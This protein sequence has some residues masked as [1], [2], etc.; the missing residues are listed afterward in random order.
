MDAI[1]SFIIEKQESLAE[2]KFSRNGKT[3]DLHIVA[4]NIAFVINVAAT[5][6]LAKYPPTA[7]LIYD[8]P[9]FENDEKE[10]EAVKSATLEILSHV[11]E[12]GFKA[13]VEVKVGVLSSQHEG[14]YFRVKFIARDPVTGLPLVDYSQPMKVISKR[15]QVK[16]IMERKEA[17][18]A[19]EDKSPKSP[20]SPQPLVGIKRER[21][22]DDVANSLVRLELQQQMQMAMLEQ[23][24]SKNSTPA[25]KD[26]MDFE[27]AF[28]NFLSAFKN[29]PSEERPNKIRRVM[30]TMV[31][32]E[33]FCEFVGLAQQDLARGTCN[34]EGLFNLGLPD[35]SSK[36][37]S[38]KSC[39]ADYCPHKKQLERLD[40]LYND[41]LLEPLSPVSV[42]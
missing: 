12:T 33:E 4:K 1:P 3:I 16:K 19:K 23:L 6:D 31:E 13:A 20:S 36:F 39:N 42:E 34:E 40:V 9:S 18:M 17:K 15:N 26:T 41:F 8:S 29:I 28:D 5:F 32:K 22:S 25:P 38:E 35:C 14:S 7:K 30:K 2:D 37:C 27:A 24:L 21:P 11:D 10:V